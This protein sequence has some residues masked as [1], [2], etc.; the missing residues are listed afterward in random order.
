MQAEISSD[1]QRKICCSKILEGFVRK[2]V[3]LLAH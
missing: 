1:I 3:G 2:V